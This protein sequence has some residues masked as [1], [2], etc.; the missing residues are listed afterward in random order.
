[1]NINTERIEHAKLSELKTNTNSEGLL[2]E[3]ILHFARVLRKAGIPVGSGQVLDAVRAVIT[4]GLFN[5]SDFYTS[6]L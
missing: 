6:C 1:M 4:I 3:N 2:V 5:R